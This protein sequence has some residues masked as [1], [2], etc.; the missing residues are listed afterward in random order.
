MDPSWKMN[1]CELQSSTF[2]FGNMN[3]YI[4]Q[5][6]T[7]DEGAINMMHRGPAEMY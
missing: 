2:S 7:N 1:R 3:F 5:P 4:M 6:S